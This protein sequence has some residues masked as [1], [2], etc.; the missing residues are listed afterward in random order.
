MAG[1]LKYFEPQR[2]RKLPDPEGP[3]AAYI[4]TNAIRFANKEVAK[5]KTFRRK[6]FSD[7][8]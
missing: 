6:I 3:L 5:L 4:P 7:I 2:I 1:I 8:K